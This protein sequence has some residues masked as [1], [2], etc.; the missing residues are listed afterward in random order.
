MKAVNDSQSGTR[1]FKVGDLVEVL[2]V[3]E[4]LATL[5]D[6]GLLDGMP[7][8]PE[9]QQYCGQHVRIFKVVTKICDTIDKTGFR[10]MTKTVALEG[11]HCSGDFH[12][13]CQASC[14]LFWK[15]Q[16]LKP[17][18]RSADVESTFIPLQSV[19]SNGGEHRGSSSTVQPSANILGWAIRPPVAGDIAPVYVCQIT[20]LKEAS[21][22]LPWWDPRAYICDVR[23]GNRGLWEVVRW[24][25]IS[26]FNWVQI[27]RGGVGY[28]YVE[29]GA[30]KHTPTANLNLQPGD[31]VRVKSED[32]I[33]KTLDVNNKNR[34]LWF[35]M[36]MLPLSGN[37]FRVTSRVQRIVHEKSGKMIAMASDAPIILLEG[38]ICHGN[39]HKFCPR[40]E[41]LFWREAWLER[42]ESY[43]AY[44]DVQ[45]EQVGQAGAGR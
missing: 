3:Q 27:F 41:Y 38:Q 23:S 30:L 19:S 14:L 13:G 8:M 31:L 1:N 9:M 10:R 26:L 45:V 44:G 7:F 37:I 11:L 36:E 42:V 20:Q 17:I 43:G 25:L 21:S 40:S 32:Q 39:F 33:M 18:S 15:E 34:G 2:S 4:I 6:R 22:L 12:G 5:D 28:P 16:W 24:L 29:K 35:D